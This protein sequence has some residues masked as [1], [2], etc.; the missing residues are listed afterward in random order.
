[1]IQERGFSGAH[2][3]K[4]RDLVGRRF[5]PAD[6]HLDRRP[7][8]DKLPPCDD[9]LQIRKRLYPDLSRPESR[10]ALGKVAPD[11]LADVRGGLVDQPLQVL[12]KLRRLRDAFSPRAPYPRSLF[13]PSSAN[14]DPDERNADVNRPTKARRPDV[15][16]DLRLAEVRKHGRP[17]AGEVILNDFCFGR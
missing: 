8:F 11:P 16:R 9:L 15:E 2:P 14:V 10:E 7:E 5:E 13:G 4:D 6:N 12:L 1:M 17:D 3:P